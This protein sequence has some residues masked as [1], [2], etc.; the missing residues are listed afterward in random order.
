M[1]GAMN[2]RTGID[3]ATLMRADGLLAGWRGQGLESA[4]W[5][6]SQRTA[7]AACLT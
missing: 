5:R 7:A 1:L 6:V 2:I 4:I 3:M